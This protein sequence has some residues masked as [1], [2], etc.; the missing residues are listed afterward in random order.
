MNKKVT[1]ND[2]SLKFKSPQKSIIKNSISM[3]NDFSS[4]F[5]KFFEAST[6]NNLSM[7]KII[8]EI[9][10][11]IVNNNPFCLDEQSIKCLSSLNKAFNNIVVSFNQFYLNS[12]KYFGKSNLTKR[13]KSSLS[14]KK[15]KLS[16]KFISSDIA[17]DNND[18]HN[19]KH[20]KTENKN[21]VF[22][23]YIKSKIENNKSNYSKVKSIKYYSIDVGNNKNENDQ[24]SYIDL[25]ILD[26]NFIKNIKSLLSILKNEKKKNINNNKNTKT[27]LRLDNLKEK[28]IF[29]LSNKLNKGNSKLLAHRRIKSVNTEEI[30]NNNSNIIVN[31]NENTFNK[32]LSDRLIKKK[33][34]K[35]NLRISEFD[36]NKISNTTENLEPSSFLDSLKFKSISSDK[37]LNEID[38]TKNSI[39]LNQ[40]EIVKLQTEVNILE[41]NKKEFLNQIADLITRNNSLTQEISALN[42]KI[43][44]AEKE[45]NLL[46]NKINELNIK[47]E[48]ITNSKNEIEKSHLILK[49]TM[50]SYEKEKAL[51]LIELN[52]ALNSL[53]EMKKENLKLNKDKDDIENEINLNKKTIRD[54]NIQIAQLGKENEIINNILNDT[55]NKK[56]EFKE[57]YKKISKELQDEKEI[58]LFMEKKIKK[59]EKKLEEHN[60]NDFYDTKTKT[61]KLGLMNKVNEI[62]VEK[63]QKKYTS[64]P[65][66]YRKNTSTFSTN[67]T[68][69]MKIV[70]NNN[71][72]EQELTPENFTI[73]KLFK[74]DNL[75]WFLLKKIK[76]KSPEK[77]A[78]LSPSQSQSKYRRYRILK[79]NSKFNNERKDESYSDFIWKSNKNENDFINFD[80][81]NIEN[82]EDNN[83]YSREKQKKINELETCIKDLEE[84][85]EKK[86]N[87]CNRINLNYA[88]L[89]KRTKIPDETYDKLIENLEK[90]KKENKILKKKI[91]N[92]KSTQD[93]I[94]I[95]FIEDDLE[96]SKFIDDKCF[97][98]ILD[99]L[100]ENKSRH[101]TYKNYKTKKDDNY[102][103][104]MMKFFKS[105]GDDNKE[106][107]EEN[108]NNINNDANKEGIKEEN[109]DNN[110][111]IS[112]KKYEYKR[113]F[114]H[115]IEDNKSPNSKSVKNII[116]KKEENISKE[117]NDLNIDEKK[118][119]NN[120]ET[121]KNDNWANTR[122]TYNKKKSENKKYFFNRYSKNKRLTNN[123]NKFSN[124]NN[125][126]DNNNEK[127]EDNEK[128][129]E[130]EKKE[131]EFR[132]IMSDKNYIKNKYLNKNEKDYPLKESSNYK[133]KVKRFHHLN[134]NNYLEKNIG[135]KGIKEFSIIKTENDEEKISNNIFSNTKRFRRTY[136]RN[137]EENNVNNIK[138]DFKK[139][140]N[141]DN[142]NGEKIVEN[143]SYKALKTMKFENQNKSERKLELQDSSSTNHVYRGR[144]FYK[145]RQENLKSEANE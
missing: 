39:S 113:H 44:E 94:R 129:K 35:K 21:L 2:K 136:K 121:I 72:V 88:K 26:I 3:T 29:Q 32:N 28:L 95:S 23:N 53:E 5:Y 114:H 25:N 81:N 22:K 109:S 105:H 122:R 13:G 19:I 77:G 8:N 69:H 102:E 108:N 124:N 132:I 119:N 51:K 130:K 71:L 58:N 16:Q 30:S 38:E 89:F 135:K 61:Y 120:K 45:K 96:G 34:E 138:D 33:I 85:L 133:N 46:N 115:K 60:I 82:I 11:K 6:K 117:K 31:I 131:N 47:L 97:E 18:S 55:T 104:N 78:E 7:K 79:M 70:N 125:T 59:L 12:K 74:L 15:P 80:L 143:K 127:V 140:E 42:L 101:N 83:E 116:N 103:I 54:L 64:P 110:K 128:E 56:E 76:K 17:S 142:K 57:K 112:P 49:E 48:L 67:N 20:I 63:L 50:E 37:N 75:K 10:V 100:V 62:E 65:N 111:G 27:Q 99:A 98:E 41:K 91:D 90:L 134:T 106:I 107:N 1:N 92:F 9:N 145:K 43:E 141:I 87:D 66:N 14:Y 24:N 52:K 144:Q 84:K 4:I 40:I 68:S 36:K 118:E 139:D 73:V 126:I 123:I 86:E 93:F 137:Q